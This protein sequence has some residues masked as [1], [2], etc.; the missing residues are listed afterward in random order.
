MRKRQ[1]GST[2]IEISEIAFGAGPVSGLMSS[3]DI[4]KQSAVVARAIERGVNWFDT[5]AT[6]CEGQ[7]EQS[8]G[9]ILE[10]LGCADRVHVAT[11]A[12]VMPDQLRDIG[13]HV[14][15][16]VTQS[17]ARLRCNR[18]TLLQL[19]NSITAQRGDMPTSLSPQDVLGPGGVL[20]AFERLK[21]QGVVSHIG[22]TGI[23]Q[24]RALREVIRSGAFATIQIPY[25][26]LN[27][28][29]GQTMPTGFAETDFGNVIADCKQQ[30]MGVLAIRVFAAGALLG[31]KPSAHTLKTPFFPLDLYNRDLAAAKRIQDALQGRMSAHELAIR[32]ALSHPD[33][34][35]AIVGFGQ[36]AHVDAVWKAASAGPLP[37]EV[38]DLIG[39]LG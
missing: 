7:S 22:L 25:H 23:G 24:P 10:N 31:N 14:I 13:W 35:A 2:G 30:N 8:L 5:A 33:I 17:L 15:D 18:L 27:P 11:K 36:P 26:L 1:L 16:S 32:F 4:E 38:L 34:S 39:S 12:R 29:A 6:Y 21:S 9:Q 37:Q 3:A 28:S 20:E 19:H